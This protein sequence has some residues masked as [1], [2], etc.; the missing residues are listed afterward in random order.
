MAG[1]SP[2]SPSFQP[3]RERSFDHEVEAGLATF[4]PSPEGFVP[5]AGAHPEEPGAGAA[6]ASAHDPAAAPSEAI[7][8]AALKFQRETTLLT[9]ADAFAASIRQEAEL[10]VKQIRA[11]VDLLNSQAEARYAEAQRAKEQADADGAQALADVNAQVE[12]IR[13]E[14]YQDGFDAGH[15]EGLRK[16]YEEAG[17]FLRNMERILDEIS[18]FRRRVAFH[19][20]KDSIR[21]AVLLAK[22]ILRQELTVNKKAALQ[23]L[24]KTLADLEGTG[25]FRVWLNPEDYR[26]A[27]A[28]RPQLEKFLGEGQTL[29]LRAKPDLPLGSVLIESDR[30]VIDLTLAAQFHHLDHLLT[31]ALNERETVV[32][33]EPP[34]PP[35]APAPAASLPETPGGSADEG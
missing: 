20:E 12:A 28:A 31:Q 29:T 15:E 7:D 1:D 5:T 3:Y 18:R 27:G 16:R 6:F 10:Y 19:V 34:R 9:N 25:T 24:A 17:V 26:F 33:K 11:E 23:L 8:F 21:I 32:T 13:R 22:K 35:A 14:A 4:A 30:E 2:F